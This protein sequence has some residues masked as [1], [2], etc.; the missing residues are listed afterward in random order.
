MKFENQEPIFFT[1]I[2][3]SLNS[4]HIFQGNYE[5]TKLGSTPVPS[6][7][8][9]C[10]TISNGCGLLEQ[11]RDGGIATVTSTVELLSQQLLLDTN[12]NNVIPLCQRFLA[13]LIPEEDSD[14]GNEDLPFDAY[15]TG[16]EMDGELGS[17]GLS[18]IV[19]FQSTGHASFNGYRIN[20]KSEHDDPE[21]DMLG[22]T[23]INSNFSHSLN[24]TAPDQPVAGMVCSEFQYESMKIN[25]RLFLEAQS[26]GIFLE[27]LVGLLLHEYLY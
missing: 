16:F 22:N 5:L 15:G 21:I 14:S 24:G 18:H 11:E 25:D 9:G 1:T 27:P 8:D 4:F 20:E 23:G 26:I 10:S 3:V 6:I 13:A 19:N 17:N 7:T 12:D 2:F